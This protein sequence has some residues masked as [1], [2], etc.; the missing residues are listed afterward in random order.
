MLG[1]GAQAIGAVGGDAQLMTV[2]AESFRDVCRRLKVVFY[3]QN[4]HDD[5]LE[6]P[7]LDYRFPMSPKTRSRRQAMR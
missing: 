5:V 1:R 2:G 4:L 3:E 6:G 7:M